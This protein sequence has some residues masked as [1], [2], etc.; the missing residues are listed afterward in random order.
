MRFISK[1]SNLLIVL[2]PG[3]SAQPLTGTPSIPTVSVRF[4][5]GLADV[6]D[7]E[8]TDMMLRHPGYEGDFISAESVN[9]IDPYAYARQDSE[10]QHVV[11]EL[12]FGS[13]VG[14]QV[15]GGKTNLSPEVA[16]LVQEM[17]TAMAKEMLPT[18]VESVL[19]TMLKT[20]DADKVED[21]SPEKA[22]AP[23][24]D[25]KP[26][27]DKKGGKAASVKASKASEP[28]ESEAANPAQVDEVIA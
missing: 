10:P 17:A 4:K 13:P 6:P 26:A 19:Q 7:G 11:T 21:T 3:L 28:E 16:K 5:E 22:S 18:M 2:R 24:K 25:T 14:R 9:N 8:L 23:T 15:S 27:A 1:S 20:R 12:K